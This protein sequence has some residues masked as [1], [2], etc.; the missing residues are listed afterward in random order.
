MIGRK[1]IY[2]DTLD[3]TNNY[4]A[5]LESEGKIEHGTV[6]LAESQEAGKG[7]RGAKWDSEPYKNLTLSCYLEHDNLAVSQ[8]FALNQVISLACVD[9]L[10]HF[11]AGFEVKW[12]NDIVYSSSKITGILIENQLQGEKIRSSIVG[13]GININQREFGDYNATSL[14]KICANEFILREIIFVLVEKLNFW[15]SKLISFDFNSIQSAYLQNLW[16]Y[17]KESQFQDE[18]GSFIGVIQGVELNGQILI[19]VK[20][21]IKKY[22]NKE[23]VFLERIKS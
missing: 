17:Q 11:H 13:L 19:Q 23:I 10:N 5:N 3:S 22:Q 1:I 2:K 15:Y 14:A 9:F 7:Q 18:K 21:E 12:P 20:D 16:L 6:I 4:V 8:H